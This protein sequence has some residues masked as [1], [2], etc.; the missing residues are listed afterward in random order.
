MS[1]PKYEDLIHWL[2]EAIHMLIEWRPDF[3]EPDEIKDYDNTVD[4][5]ETVLKQAKGEL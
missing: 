2:E 3:I 5:M 4:Q 1:K